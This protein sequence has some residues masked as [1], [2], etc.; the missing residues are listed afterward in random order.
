MEQYSAAR[1]SRIAVTKKAPMGTSPYPAFLELV[2]RQLRQDYDE[3]DLRSEGL[4][5][6]TTLDTRVQA[7]AERALTRRLAQYD[8]DRRFGD[9]GL[10]GAVV[11]TDSQTG[12]VQA[13]V[14]GRDP[15]YRGYNR[16]LNAARPV[17]SL[18]KPAIYLT[19]L[20]EPARYTL[21]TPLDDG[22]FVWKSRGAKDWEPAN[23]DKQFHGA[24]PLRVALAQSYNVAAAR[25]GTELGVERVLAAVRQLGVQRELRPLASTL[26]GAAEM[27]PFEVAQMYQTIAAGG[28]RPPLRAIREVLT[29]DHQPLRRYPLSVEQAFAPEP[30]YLLTAAMQDVVREGTGRGLRNW[31]PPETAVAGKTGTT[32]EQ[33]D[34]WFAGFTGNRLAVVW[35]G[36]DDNRAARLTG[37]AAALPV[38]GEM[39]AGLDIEP[40]AAP[41]PDSI[42]LVLIDPQTG[43]LADGGCPGAVEV[44]FAQGSAP[45][46]RAPCAGDVPARIRSWFE[47]LFN[48]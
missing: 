43:L 14:G 40:L 12:E 15:R 45:A 16:A 9:A 48:R 3:A 33:R 28:F 29:Q 39:M 4:R 25:L 38:W 5:I 19:A 13:V 11:A 17:G 44:P 21:L 42:H 6:F 20:S 36:Y 32:D 47:K 24:V 41:K 22:P 23:Y 10:E 26:L 1:A 2:H 35:V 7:A 30:V 8:R 18:L 34:S 37:S 31:L 46:E 27:S